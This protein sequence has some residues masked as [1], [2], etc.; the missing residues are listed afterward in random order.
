MNEGTVFS[1]VGAKA[2]GFCFL[3]QDKLMHGTVHRK[4]QNIIG[5]ITVRSERRVESPESRY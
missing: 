5:N 1:F 2:L 4:I 3:F